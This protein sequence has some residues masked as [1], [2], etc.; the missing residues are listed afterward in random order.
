MSVRRV[1]PVPP[2]PLRRAGNNPRL[3]AQHER[4]ASLAADG[5]RDLDREQ[6]PHLR[7]SGAGVNANLILSVF[8]N[9]KL[10]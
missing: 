2:R 7:I 1:R 9:L 6:P 3:R 5:V 4:R 8:A 10:T